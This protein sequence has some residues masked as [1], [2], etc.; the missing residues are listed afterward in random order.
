M[1][2]IYITEPN[3][4]YSFD[5]PVTPGAE[6][7]IGTAPNCQLSLPGVDGLSPLHARIFCQPEG[8]VIE[9]LGSQYGTL[10]NGRPVLQPEFMAYGVEYRMAAAA[11][12][13][14]PEDAPAAQPTAPADQ[15]AAAQ[16]TAAPAAAAAATAAAAG[17]AKKTTPAAG[18]LK[19]KTVAKAAPAVAKK[20]AVAPAAGK[21]TPAPA[22]LKKTAGAKPL[23]ALADKYA[24]S[25]TS[26]K[27]N[28]I[29]LV[30]LL[31]AALYAGIALHHWERSGNFLPFIMQDPYVPGKAAPAAQAPKAEPAAAA[32]DTEGV[33]AEEAEE[34]EADDAAETGDA[35]EADDAAET[36]DAGEADAEQDEES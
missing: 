29:Y 17:T 25:N 2:R 28:M 30:A 6:V 7:L 13:L 32:E 14:V 18:A 11:I 19:K 10:A 15:P 33:E 1:P 16:P 9:D 27:A 34:T 31:L 23:S 24:R 3:H 36:D 21:K 4:F 8:Y 12:S 35:G 5:L 26:T 22:G 20:T